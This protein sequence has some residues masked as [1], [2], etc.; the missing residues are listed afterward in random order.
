[1]AHCT[2]RSSSITERQPYSSYYILEYPDW[3]NTIAVTSDGQLFYPSVPAWSA[4]DIE[5]TFAGVCEKEDASRW[6]PQRELLEETGYGNG[7]LAGIHAISPTR[8]PIPTL[9]IV[10]S[11]RCRKK[12]WEQHFEDTE[13]RICLQV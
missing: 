8:V 11:Y 3:V 2:Q 1:M 5:R 6:L 12:I 10:P 4:T 13:K 7:Q 9:R